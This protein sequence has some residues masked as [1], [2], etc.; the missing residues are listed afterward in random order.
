M[1]SPYRIQSNNTNKRM[2]KAKKTIVNNDSDRELDLRRPQTTSNDLK[3]T[4]KEPVKNKKS[5]LKGGVN[6]EFTE[7][8]LDKILKNNDS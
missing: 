2:K 6:I 1:L 4:S 7:H 3:S 5:K 8:F